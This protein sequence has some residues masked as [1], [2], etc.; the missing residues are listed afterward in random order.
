VSTFCPVMFL[1]L[2]LELSFGLLFSPYKDVSINFNWN[3]NVISTRIT[4]SFT[5]I[6]SVLPS[7][8][9]GLTWAFASGECGHENWA[10]ISASSIASVNIPL[11]TQAN[12]NYVISTGGA[13]G[14]FTCSSGDGML[15]F[16]SRYNSKNLI[17]VDFDIE[18]SLSQ[19]QINSLVKQIAFAQTHYPRLRYSFTLATLAASDGSSASLNTAGTWVLQALNQF[20]MTNFTIN[21]MTMD[22]GGTPNP[23][24]CVVGNGVCDMGRS[25]IQAAKNVNSKFGIPFSKIGITPMIGM[26]DVTN[27][28]TSLSDVHTLT[29]WSVSN[30]ISGLHYWSFDRDAPCQQSWAS[31]ICSSTPVPYFGYVKQFISSLN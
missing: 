10:G 3:T 18:G 22:F 17:G 25:A 6:L 21:L 23:S 4:G 7:G 13:G 19:S 14:T 16:I 8:V 28:I 26:N 31:P 30:K 15:T 1:L 2:F 9:R 20:G 11:F 27:E 5:P 24:I 29:Q 12:I